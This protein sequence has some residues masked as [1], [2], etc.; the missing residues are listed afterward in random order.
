MKL[1]TRISSVLAL[2]VLI[3]SI[4]MA[5]DKDQ[6]WGGQ[7]RHME[8]MA[9]QLELTDD[10]R[11]QWENLHEVHHPR[12]REI[13][14]EM[15]EHRKALKEA[16][17]NGFNEAEAEAAARQIGALTAEASLLKARMHSEVNEILTEEQREEFNQMHDKRGKRGHGMKHHKRDKPAGEHHDANRQ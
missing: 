15:Q 3:P 11:E 2:F 16:S 6:H 8:H 7:G 9:E 4:S 12:M 5:D 10:Q 17:T 14:K 1:F 13:H